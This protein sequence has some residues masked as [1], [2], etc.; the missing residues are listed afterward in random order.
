LRAR[1]A[2]KKRT[3]EFFMPELN[4]GE[5]ARTVRIARNLSQSDLAIKCG[6]SSREVHLFEKNE[7]VRMDVKLRLLQE[8]WAD[9]IS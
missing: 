6:V 5:W 4:T 1:E 7:P 9:R 3:G 2:E 8:L